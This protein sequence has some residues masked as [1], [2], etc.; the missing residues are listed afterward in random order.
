MLPQPSFWKYR[1][2]FTKV[3]QISSLCSL[4]KL[5]NSNNLFSA[6]RVIPLHIQLLISKNFNL[7]VHPLLVVLLATDT[8]VCHK[9]SIIW[10]N[11]I[12]KVG[13]PTETIY[14]KKQKNRLQQQYS[15]L[16]FGNGE[17]FTNCKQTSKGSW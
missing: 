2:Y 9:I 17:K 16:V 8:A 4:D 7:N 5:Y 11:I 10:Y 14:T 1:I 15:L 3:L 6:N 13:F 12:M